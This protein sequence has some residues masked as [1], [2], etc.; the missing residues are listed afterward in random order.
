[1]YYYE[2]DVKSFIHNTDINL[3]IVC[4]CQCFLMLRRLACFKRRLNEAVWSLGFVNQDPVSKQV[5]H[6]K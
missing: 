4:N 6:N 3:E 1:M 5:W 2:F